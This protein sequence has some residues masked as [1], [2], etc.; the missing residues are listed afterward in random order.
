M[1]KHAPGVEW[2]II[3]SDADWERFSAPPLLEVPPPAGSR[4]KP[5]A[6]SIAVL[7]LLLAGAGGLLWRADRTTPQPTAEVTAAAQEDPGSSEP[8]RPSLLATILGDQ[9]ANVAGSWQAPATSLPRTPAQA[10]EP[11][12]HVDVELLTLDIHDD[13]AMAQVI[14]RTS[15]GAPPYRQTRFYQRT[16]TSWLPATQEAALSWPKR[17]LET[18][19][20]VYH[21]RQHD[22]SPVFA[23]VSKMDAL[24][25]TMLRNF[26]L[27][28]TPGAEKLVIEVSV[29][30]PPGL[31]TPQPASNARFIVA[32]PALY[33]APVE[34]T[35][36]DLLAQSLALL[37]LDDVIAQA[38]ERFALDST[39]QPMLSALRLWQVWDL[40]MPLAIWRKEVVKW[41]YHDLSFSLAGQPVV[42]PDHYTELCAAHKL[43]MPH[44][45]ALNIPLGCTKLDWGGWYWAQ[46]GPRASPT[47]LDRFFMPQPNAWAMQPFPV[48]HP[49]QTVA[50]AT[51]V[52]YAVAT[53]G[54]E[55]LPALVAGLGQHERWE[56]LIPAVFGVTAAEFEAGWQAHLAAHYGVSPAAFQP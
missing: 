3:E 14:I 56:T 43:W 10:A 47:R 35:D 23:V 54:R 22:A 51:L 21:Y 50:L 18:P 6:W 49:G 13:Q 46:W 15:D 20:L 28:H 41:V 2:T 11:N 8:G 24:Y 5:Y 45:L 55:R 4:L 37:L 52:E 38:S 12:A 39:W 44:P 33:L 7:F 9:T 29:T 26:G 16:A 25:T 30:H 1:P 31:N 17:S 42:L 32:S 53:Y 36:A 27:P 48:S 40:D 19:Y 34:L